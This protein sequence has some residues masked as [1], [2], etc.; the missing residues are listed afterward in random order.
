ML[1]HIITGILLVRPLAQFFIA[2][3]F[4]TDFTVK[5]QLWPST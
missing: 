2:A 1:C 4:N 5:C 3:S